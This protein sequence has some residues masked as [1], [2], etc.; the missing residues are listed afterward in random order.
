M[1]TA[2]TTEAVPAAEPF[3]RF[4]AFRGKVPLPW[5]TIGVLAVLMAAGD[6]FVLTSLQGA[7]GAIERSQAR[8]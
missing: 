6:G 8:S 2:T 4:A 3:V 5:I 7:V 1:S